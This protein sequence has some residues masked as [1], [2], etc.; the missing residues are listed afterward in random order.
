VIQGLSTFCRKGS[1]GREVHWL[2]TWGLSKYFISMENSRFLYDMTGCD[3]PLS[4]VSGLN[5]L[6]QAEPGWELVQSKFLYLVEW[7]T[8]KFYFIFIDE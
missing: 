2:N 4:E 1:S 6:G 8:C 5:V 3:G 7:S